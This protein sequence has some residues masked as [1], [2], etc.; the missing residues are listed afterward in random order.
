MVQVNIVTRFEWPVFIRHKRLSR[1]AV[2]ANYKEFASNCSPTS[3]SHQ[4]ETRKGDVRIGAEIRRD[5]FTARLVEHKGEEIRASPE[6]G[7]V[8]TTLTDEA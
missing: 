6:V 4:I 3:I 8:R 7:L 5:D 2:Y 1:A